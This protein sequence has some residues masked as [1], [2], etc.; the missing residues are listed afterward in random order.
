MTG[1]LWSLLLVGLLLVIGL[2]PSFIKRLPVTS[3]INYLSIGLFVGPTL[4]N[5]FHF[6]PLRE[7]AVLEV[8]TEVA[9]LISLFA[10]GVKMPAPMRLD[11]WRTPLILASASMALSALSSVPLSAASAGRCA[12]DVLTTS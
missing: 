8:L 11:R 6:N 12:A 2:T 1:A 9:V 5:A 3:A 4:L 10:F 7:S